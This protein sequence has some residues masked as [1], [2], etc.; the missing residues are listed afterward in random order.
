MTLQGKVAVVTGGSRGI[1]RAVATVLAREGAVITLCARDRVLLEKVAAELE[2]SGVQALAVQADV[3]R[4]SEVEQMIGACVERFGQVD[5]LVNNA[6]ITRDNLLLRMKDEEWDAV[7]STNLK[8]VFHCTRAVLRPMIKQRSGRIINLTSVV[9]V[10]GNPGQANY[11]AAKAGIIGL[12]KATAREVASRGITAN[13]VAPG[14]IETDMTHALDL[15]LQE[16]MRSQI[17]L[18]RFGRPED[19]AELVAFLASDRAAYITGQVIHLNGGLW[20]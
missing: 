5:I 2:S 6:G 20:M 18:G 16:Q 8:G 3:T 10:M 1:G 19:V 13:A 17:P 4:A 7:L 11:V 9:A 12:T 15:E 14:F